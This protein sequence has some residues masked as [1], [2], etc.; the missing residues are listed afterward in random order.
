MTAEVLGLAL[1]DVKMISDDT[2]LCP[3][4]RT[5]KGSMCHGLSEALFEEMVFN[6]KERLMNPTLGDYKIPPALYVPDMD[7]II[8]ESNEPNG[9]FGAKEVGESC[10]LPV[11]PAIINAIRDAC[12]V[13]IIELPITSEKILKSLKSKEAAKAE[14][15][16]YKPP[17]NA[18]KILAR[19][20]ELSN[21]T[22]A[23]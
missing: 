5:L 21:G 18:D 8:I 13:V 3:I 17:A 10:I 11:V 12:G 7:A 2:V 23:R 19:A 14:Q 1:E 15:Y 20:A 16:V 22:Y 9:P 4:R 6:N